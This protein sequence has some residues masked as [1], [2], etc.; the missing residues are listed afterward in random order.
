MNPEMYRKEAEAAAAKA[1]AAAAA[2]AEAAAE[3]REAARRKRQE[4][5]FRE[6]AKL[7]AEQALARRNEAL[8]KMGYS[9]YAPKL[10]LQSSW[11]FLGTLIQ[12][13]QQRI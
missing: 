2:K 8:K 3:R 7:K 9:K 1:K 5:S 4:M 12:T 6:R 10:I 11:D 13:Y